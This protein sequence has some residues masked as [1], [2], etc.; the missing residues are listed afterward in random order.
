MNC[1]TP[2][3]PVPHSLREFAQTHVSW[4]SDAIQLSHPLSSPSPLALNLSHH[5]GLPTSQFFASGS[6]SIGA[7]ASVL[8]MNWKGWFPLGLTG[9]ICLLS[10]GLSR[11]FSCTTVWKHQFFSIQPPLWTKLSHPYM[12]TGKTIALTIK[13]FIGKVMS[14]LFNTLSRFVITVLPKSKYLLISWLQSPSTLILEPK[15]VRSDSFHFF[16]LYLS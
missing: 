13:T 2:D 10:K 9:L 7:S 8:P 1:Y 12:T 14:L 11:V 15:K 6:Q 16:P 3:F 5:Q 4:V